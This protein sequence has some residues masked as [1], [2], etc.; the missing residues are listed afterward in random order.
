MKIDKDAH[1][2]IQYPNDAVL[3]SHCEETC[4]RRPCT[5]N[6]TVTKEVGGVLEDLKYMKWREVVTFLAFSELII[7]S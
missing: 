7:F 4:I 5:T 1:I 2:P 6:L 3:T